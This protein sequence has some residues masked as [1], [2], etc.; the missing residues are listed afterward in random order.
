M[1]V[2]AE[3]LLLPGTDSFAMTTDQENENFRCAEHP[4]VLRMAGSVLLRPSG[5]QLNSR[6]FSLV[7]SRRLHPRK[8]K[9]QSR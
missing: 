2:D 1:D 9:R 8:R 7:A 3:A 4:R 6:D 5:G